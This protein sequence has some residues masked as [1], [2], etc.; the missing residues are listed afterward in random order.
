M[1]M[2]WFRKASNG[3]ACKVNAMLLNRMEKV[4]LVSLRVLVRIKRLA[5]VRYRSTYY[6]N[7]CGVDDSARG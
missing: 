1:R 6:S 3:K 4:A 5:K 2:V 7:S